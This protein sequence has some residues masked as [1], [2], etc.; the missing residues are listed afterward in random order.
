MQAFQVANGVKRV[1]GDPIRGGY[2]SHDIFA[3]KLYK[4]CNRSMLWMFISSGSFNEIDNVIFQLETSRLRWILN[5]YREYRISW[6]Q[7]K[8]EPSRMAALYLKAM[9]RFMRCHQAI[10][11]YDG[12]HLEIESC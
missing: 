4:L 8:H 7:S 11:S 6:E 1:A 9:R 10:A 5:R 2:Q 3:R 12:G